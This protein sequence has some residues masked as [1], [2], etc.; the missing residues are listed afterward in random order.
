MCSILVERL[1]T[2]ANVNTTGFFTLP[3]YWQFANQLGAYH[4]LPYWSVYYICMR[5]WARNDITNVINGGEG[6]GEQLDRTIVLSVKTPWFSSIMTG[7]A[8]PL[9]SLCCTFCIHLH[10]LVS[11]LKKPVYRAIWTDVSQSL[12]LSISTNISIR[13]ATLQCCE[14]SQT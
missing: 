8:G 7:G 3:M 9:Y 4:H 11:D 12:H 5:A 1:W 6:I 2:A 13:L 10:H 14:S